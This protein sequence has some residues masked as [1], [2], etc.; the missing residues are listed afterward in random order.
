MRHLDSAPS[1]FINKDFEF[2]G[3]RFDDSILAFLTVKHR[4]TKFLW[5]ASSLS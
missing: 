2:A 4:F 1:A 5:F 3:S